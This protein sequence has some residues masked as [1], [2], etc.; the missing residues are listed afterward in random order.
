M[1]TRRPTHFSETALAHATAA[2]TPLSKTTLCRRA[3][4]AR[5]MRA[6]VQLGDPVDHRLVVQAPGHPLVI[7]VSRLP[8]HTL[9]QELLRSF[10]PHASRGARAISS[11]GRRQQRSPSEK[12]WKFMRR[13]WNCSTPKVFRGSHWAGA[14][15]RIWWVPSVPGHTT[16]Y[17]ALRAFVRKRP[18]NLED[19]ALESITNWSVEGRSRAGFMPHGRQGI[20]DSVG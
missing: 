20:R 1:W 14:S 9:C 18:G 12:I 17:P 10:T 16:R 13:R 4:P 3:W 19:T 7:P 11:P 6:C 15:W 2:C 8:T 5:L